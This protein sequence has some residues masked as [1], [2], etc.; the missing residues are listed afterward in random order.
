MLIR[1]CVWYI[2]HRHAN[3]EPE[4]SMDNDIEDEDNEVQVEDNEVQE[5]DA[6]DS[7]DDDSIIL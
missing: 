5:G 7:D 1:V 4:E 2:F 6:L 3:V